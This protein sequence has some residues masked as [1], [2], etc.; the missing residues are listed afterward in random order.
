MPLRESISNWL[1][2]PLRKP[3]R[4]CTEGSPYGL[5]GGGVS[6]GASGLASPGPGRPLSWPRPGWASPNQMEAWRT[7]IRKI[8]PTSVLCSPIAPT[9]C[10]V[11]AAEAVEHILLIATVVPAAVTVVAVEVATAEGAAVEW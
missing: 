5:S 10:S 2:M 7:D 4:A 11:A 8:V 3:L 6:L 1:K 9:L